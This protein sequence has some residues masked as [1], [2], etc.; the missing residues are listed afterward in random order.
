MPRT[1]A[2]QT[3]AQRALPFLLVLLLVV[4]AFVGGLVRPPWQWRWYLSLATTVS[5][6]WGSDADRRDL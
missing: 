6:W 5:D 2:V 3:P 4:L 1:A